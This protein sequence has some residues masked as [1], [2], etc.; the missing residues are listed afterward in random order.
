MRV[1]LYWFFSDDNI[2]P[3]SSKKPKL[4]AIETYKT[5][6][7]STYNVRQLPADNRYPLDCVKHFINLKIVDDRDR[8]SRSEFQ[9]HE[10]HGKIDSVDKGPV[11]IDQI[12]CK[13]GDSFPKLVIIKGAPGVGKTTLSW[14]L[15]RR[16]SLGNIW[17]DYS[18]VVLLPLRDKSTHEAN[19]LVDLFEC[20][21][22]AT[23]QKVWEELLI[24][25]G[26][27]LLFILEGLDEFP[28][29]LRE[30]KDCVIMRLIHGKLLPASTVVI[31]SRPWALDSFEECSSR[32]DQ[33]IVVLGFTEIQIQEYI[34]QAINSGVPDGLRTYIAANPHINSAMYN[35]LYARIVVQVYMECHDRTQNIFP[36]TTTELYTS[37]CCV[38]LKRYLTDHPVKEKWNG[39]LHELPQSLQPHFLHL[40]QISHKGIVQNENQLIFYEDDI[41]EG[42]TTLGFMNSVHPLHQSITKTASPSFNFIHLTLQEFLAAIHIWR[43]YSQQDQL[44]FI[45]TQSKIYD[46][47]II[48]FLAGLT[49]LSD[50]WTKC[51]LPTPRRRVY[52]RKPG[53]MV[54]SLNREHILWLYE[55]QNDKLISSFDIIELSVSL[56]QT[57]M[58]PKVDPLYFLALGYCIAVGNLVLHLNTHYMLNN[59]YCEQNYSHLLA[60]LKRHNSKCSSQV[61]VLDIEHITWPFPDILY[62]IFNYIPAATQGVLHVRNG[63]HM[64]L[65]NKLSK[66]LENVETIT[67]PSTILPNSL[68]ILRYSRNLKI[69]HCHIHDSETTG[70]LS[71][72]IT[73]FCTSLEYLEVR[74]TIDVDAIKLLLSHSQYLLFGLNI[75]RF[76]ELKRRQLFPLNFGPIFTDDFTEQ[77]NKFTDHFA[78]FLKYFGLFTGPTLGLKHLVSHS[79]P[80]CSLLEKLTIDLSSRPHQ[81]LTSG[82]ILQNLDI[83]F[84][85][86]GENSSVRKLY[87][88]LSVEFTLIDEFCALLQQNS[89]LEE[90]D[91]EV[92][93]LSLGTYEIQPT[94][95]LKQIMKTV[96]RPTLK[97]FV[98]TG[99][100]CRPMITNNDEIMAICNVLENNKYL[101]HLHLPKLCVEPQ[102]LFL[103]PIANALSKNSSITTL[104]LEFEPTAASIIL[105]D[106]TFERL[107]LISL[108]AKAFGD[109]LKVNKTL[110]FLYLM[111]DIPDWSPI[112]EGLKLNTTI[113]ELHIPSSAKKSAIKCIDYVHVRS[114][115]KYPLY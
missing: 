24:T 55:T 29:A 16:W 112:V 48:L 58:Q 69:L 79:L 43:T 52:N 108:E 83:I 114:R 109:M 77:A 39:K 34:D 86:L 78:D 37:Y 111:V 75:K 38:L 45:E 80:K 59:Y 101:E 53:K 2:L 73:E 41:P 57:K 84:K 72:I 40:C 63:I 110:R 18:L 66:F 56:M 47:V 60:E 50:P 98:I 17:R 28:Q 96:Y 99:D 74:V 91:I 32:I 82:Q 104:I 3:G 35:P 13:F 89:S 23:S 105:C 12:A 49:K 92:V 42:S 51:V 67:I 7:I 54:V 97:K 62:D 85:A 33:K 64:P 102:Q 76:K 93:D 36:N 44:L 90:I 61:K 4:C 11:C 1:N 9:T 81:L 46:N 5:Y 87:C 106:N 70:I 115:I 107:R 6:L 65:A 25:Q 14:E 10:V 8:F 31:T 22:E 19:N 95:M 26:K 15:C 68:E 30:T 21:D 113:R 71:D 27:G 103:L 20:G 88:K 100:F 94:L